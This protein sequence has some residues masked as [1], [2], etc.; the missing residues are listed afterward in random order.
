M[1]V[2]PRI[3]FRIGLALLVAW[4]LSLAAGATARPLKEGKS[5]AQNTDYEQWIARYVRTN[6]T[7]VFGVF[8]KGEVVP[9]K[10][11]V[12]VVEGEPN[13]NGI[14]A[15]SHLGLGV[16]TY[17][18]VISTHGRIAY[19]SH[20]DFGSKGSSGG[21][22]LSA[23]ELKKLDSLLTKLPDDGERLPPP[24]R[25]MILQ[26][27]VD[28]HWVVRVY[29]RANAPDVVWEI[30]RLC[31]SGIGSWVLDFKPESEI[32][33]RGD[34]LGGFLTLSPNGQSILFA[35]GNGPVQFWDPTTHEFLAQIPAFGW[36]CNSI[37]FSP[38]GTLAA[39]GGDQCAVLNTKDWK[40][41]TILKKRRSNGGFYTLTLPQF[42]PDGRYLVLQCNAPSL[43]IYDTRTWQ[44]VAQMPG[45]PGDALQYFPSPDGQR[46]LVQLKSHAIVLLDCKHRRRLAVL[47]TNACLTEVSFSPDESLVAAVTARSPGY[48]GFEGPFRLRVWKAKDGEPLHELRPYE[49]GC[50]RIDGLAWS[51]KGQYVLA[52]TKPGGFFTSR[53]I[54]VF[55]ARTGRNVGDFSG[56][57][58]AVTGMAILPGGKELIAG[59]TDGRIRFWNLAAG[60]KRIRAFEASLSHL[61]KYETHSLRRPL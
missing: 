18:A 38:D 48:L 57:P 60:I 16:S 7:A 15:L 21:P 47:D 36:D 43:E 29:D 3:A 40:T 23:A 17:G 2:Q 24:G 32:D 31:R 42:T 14:E 20:S 45:L 51:P 12:T 49:R 61:A 54:S 4:I 34:E 1:A 30:L 58:T 46:A 37:A 33:A 41:I 10:L 11:R 13:T 50:D 26:A 27:D 8:G 56:C 22:P 52:A 35:D 59:C 5:D 55:N 53:N 9:I 39:I 25:R 28:G 19:F 6:H 44:S